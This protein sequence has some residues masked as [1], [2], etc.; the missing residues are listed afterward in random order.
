VTSLLPWPSAYLAITRRARLLRL[1][2]RFHALERAGAMP[3]TTMLVGEVGLGREALAVELAA[4]LICPSPRAV[5]CD[6]PGC[7]RVRR[8]IHPDLSVVDVDVDEKTGKRK[9]EISIRQARE[10]SDGLASFPFEGRRRVYV[11]VSAHTPP[12][13]THAASAL[14]KTLEEPPAHACFVLLA[15][16]PARVLPTVL[17][18]SVQVRVPTPDRGELA[19]LLAAAHGLTAAEAEEHLHACVD[20]PVAALRLDRAGSAPLLSGLAALAREAFAGDA[21]AVLRLA[22]RAK[23]S[24]DAITAFSRVLLDEAA[25]TGGDGAERALQAAANVLEA[26]RRRAVLHLDAESVTAG[27]LMPLLSAGPA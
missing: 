15:G 20:D 24:P 9:E 17:S 22:V 2:E 14:L 25:R 26:D 19:E 23:A 16:N 8:G 18:R 7:G 10:I 3:G 6:C 11:F 27:A 4:A 13:N 12:L 1:L 21:L 5:P